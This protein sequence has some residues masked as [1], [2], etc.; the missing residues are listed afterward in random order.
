MDRLPHS[1]HPGHGSSSCALSIT[2]TA[3]AY[4]T[5]GNGYACSW[6][7]GHCLPSKACEGWRAA[8]KSEPDVFILSDINDVLD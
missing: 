7:G 1:N 4:G 3:S 6:T 2:V 5:S 8:K